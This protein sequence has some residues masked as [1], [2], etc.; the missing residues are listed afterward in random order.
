MATLIMPPSPQRPVRLRHLYRAAA[1]LSYAGGLTLTLS[2]SALMVGAA[3]LSTVAGAALTLGEGLRDR[4]LGLLS[5]GH[6]AA[7]VAHRARTG[8]FVRRRQGDALD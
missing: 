4:A 7:A 1:H 6:P 5:R 3:A 2:A 8:F